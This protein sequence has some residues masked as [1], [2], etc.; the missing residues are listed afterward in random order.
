MTI[1]RL[2]KGK[3]M[4]CSGGFNKSSVNRRKIC[5]KR[6]RASNKRQRV[7]VFPEPAFVYVKRAFRRNDEGR[8]SNDE[9]TPND[10]MTK[11]PGA[12]FTRFGFRHS[13]VLRHLR[14]R[15]L[16]TFVTGHGRSQL[17]R[18]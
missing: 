13:F 7:A 12:L 17:S 8:M 3:R 15:S 1:S 10:P 14:P 18:R 5:E 16:S 2:P 11:G 6:S 4:N 9:R